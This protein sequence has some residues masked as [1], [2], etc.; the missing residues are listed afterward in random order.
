M[1]TIS[2]DGMFL[3]MVRVLTVLSSNS[4]Q[5]GTCPNLNENAQKNAGKLG[6]ASDFAR[7][8]D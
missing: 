6:K 2:E 3:P 5:L 7:L 8:P 4:I 1:L